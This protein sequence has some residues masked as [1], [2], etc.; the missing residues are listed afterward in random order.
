MRGAGS[1]H[2]NGGGSRGREAGA[3]IGG[4]EER[5]DAAAARWCK[6][7]DEEE[8]DDDDEEGGEKWE[9]DQQKIARLEAQNRFFKRHYLETTVLPGGFLD[10]ETRAICKAVDRVSFLLQACYDMSG[11]Q[12]LRATRCPVPSCCALR[13]LLY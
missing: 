4:S 5:G 2:A 13:D 10:K 1:R 3:G 12:L 7:E 8:D 9:S 11:T 6:K